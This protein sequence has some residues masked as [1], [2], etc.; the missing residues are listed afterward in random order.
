MP[1]QAFPIFPT[2]KHSLKSCVCVREASVARWKGRRRCAWAETMTSRPLRP[3]WKIFRF[4]RFSAEPP[5]SVKI[6]FSTQSTENSSVGRQKNSFG[7]LCEF[8]KSHSRQ[9]SPLRQREWRRSNVVW[10][11]SWT[12]RKIAKKSLFFC[13]LS[14]AWKLLENKIK[15]SGS[16]RR[17]AIKALKKWR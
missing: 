13:S 3:Q 15:K 5:N 2:L 14:S 16:G 7:R 10:S 17:K 9:L 11:G 6:F 8:I 12:L 1:Q 4:Y